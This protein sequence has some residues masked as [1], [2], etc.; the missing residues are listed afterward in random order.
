MDMVRFCREICP[1]KATAF[2]AIGGC[3]SGRFCGISPLEG[4]VYSVVSSVA[5]RVA[6]KV[7][8]GV[9]NEFYY[10]INHISRNHCDDSS[11]TMLLQDKEAIA[12]VCLGY[13]AGNIALSLL[14]RQISFRT[15]IMFSFASGITGFLTDVVV[16][17]I[18]AQ[19]FG[20]QKAY[21]RLYCS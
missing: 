8:R 14:E 16:N 5:Y 11:G 18:Y 20:D 4:A 9:S 7:S 1:L 15:A 19:I 21:K 6:C 10:E 17:C 13:L 3:L 12:N 2:A